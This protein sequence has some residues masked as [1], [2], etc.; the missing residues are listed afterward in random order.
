MGIFDFFKKKEIGEPPIPDNERPY[1]R[2]ESYYTNSSH[3]GTPFERRVI[4]FDERKNSSFPS[5]TGLYV[6][7][8]LLLEYCSYGTYPRPKTGYPGF[9][10]FEY[11]IKNVGYRLEQ[12]EQ[13]E[14]IEMSSE[15][16][17]YHLTYFGEQELSENLYVAYMHKHKLKTAEPPQF[18]PEFNVWSINKLL[19]GVDASEWRKIVDEEEKKLV[20][21]REEHS[22]K[23]L[24]EL[25]KTDPA[26]YRKRT[27]QDDQIARINAA[28]SE[29]KQTG[30]MD[31]LISFWEDIW[32]NGGLL[33]NGSSMIFRLPDLYIGCKR[34]Q[35][36]LKIL[37]RIQKEGKYAEKAAGYIEKVNKAISKQK[38]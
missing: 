38:K 22:Q 13:R 3:E 25:K 4:P 33:F 30:D 5:K 21:W 26:M 31:G 24:E 28:E 7:E 35:D 20:K 6:A 36:A 10:W 8:I 9:W 16:G 37:K 18:G 23:A 11:G 32:V 34:Y 12:L 2:Q 19:G 29:F 14:Y 1:Y 17:K 27:S 15:T